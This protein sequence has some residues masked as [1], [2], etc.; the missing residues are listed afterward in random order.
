MA[1][2]MIRVNKAENTLQYCYILMTLCFSHFS[3]IFWIVALMPAIHSHTTM[4]IGLLAPLREHLLNYHST[5]N[6]AGY[7]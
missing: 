4:T 1:Y 6:L 7:S 5:T 2:K 3:T